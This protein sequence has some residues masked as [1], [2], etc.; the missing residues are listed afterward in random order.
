MLMINLLSTVQDDSPCILGILAA[1]CT[2]ENRRDVVY[3]YVSGI[4]V[5]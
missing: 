1:L 4:A 2:I 5:C 3:I